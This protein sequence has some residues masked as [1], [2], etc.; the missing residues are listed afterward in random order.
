M[1]AKPIRPGEWEPQQLR[2]FRAAF[3]ANP[4]LCEHALAGLGEPAPKPG[5]VRIRTDTA[6]VDLAVARALALAVKGTLVKVEL[7]DARESH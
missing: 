4:A 7:S 6:S 1:R 2:S 5:R 3:Q